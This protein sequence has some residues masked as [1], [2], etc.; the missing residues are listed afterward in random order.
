VTTSS[1]STSNIETSRKAIDLSIRLGLVAMLVALSLGILAPFIMPVLW[2]GVIAV[3]VYPL[4]LRLERWLGGR[5][6]LALTLFT[7]L[8]LAILIVPSVMLGSSMFKS[9]HTIS[10][11][12]DAGT[13]EVPPPSQSV[14]E[15]PLVGPK[16]HEIWSSASRNLSG[17]LN[18]YSE[19]VKKTATWLLGTAAGA[20]AGLL[21]FIIAVLIAAAFMANAEPIDRFMQKFSARLAGKRGQG[22][23]EL[24]GATVRS[25]AQGVLG[26]A[27]IQALLSGVGMLLAGVPAAGLW[28][29]LVLVLAVIQLPPILVLGPVA[30]YV[31]SEASTLTAVLFLAWALAV[32]A[33][34]VVLKPML[35]GRGLDVPMLVILLGA[36]GGMVFAGVIGLFVGSVVL[37]LSYRL[38][39]AWLEQDFHLDELP[40][41][42][43]KS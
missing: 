29:L 36:I 30:A 21:Q 26:V 2:A 10:T 25:V 6:K 15:W 40:D 12:L 23:G 17:T 39:L 11:Q 5:V 9:I 3:A 34:D 31:F 4:Y 7:L 16:L 1:Q 35:L 38:F 37:A 27:V 8:A 33:S 14:A 43:G 22:M 41:D 19:E 13:L 20:G 28:A 42:A 18:K 32:S 24:A